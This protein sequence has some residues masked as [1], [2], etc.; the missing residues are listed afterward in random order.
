MQTLCDFT[1]NWWQSQDCHL[2][3]QGWKLQNWRASNTISL[4]P[5]RV[6]TH[7]PKGREPVL[8]PAHSPFSFNAT[9]SQRARARAGVCACVCACVCVHESR[10]LT[11][12]TRED[13]HENSALK[14]ELW[15]CSLLSTRILNPTTL[16][17]V[18]IHLGLCHHPPSTFCSPSGMGLAAATPCL[19]PRTLF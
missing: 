17:P 5:R 16:D 10:G 14:W 6:N 1:A 9:Y 19:P 11:K 3:G 15:A 8:L 4:F 13:H 7:L 2:R 18:S 12:K